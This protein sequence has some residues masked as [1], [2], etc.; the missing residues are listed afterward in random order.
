MKKIINILENAIY[1]IELKMK[2]LSATLN[3]FL[4]DKTIV[5]IILSDPDNFNVNNLKY[6]IPK[7]YL[8]KLEYIEKLQGWYRKFPNEPQVKLALDYLADIELILKEK[9]NRYVRINIKMY[10]QCEQLKKNY[11]MLLK[12]M[13]TYDRNTFI[14]ESELSII[15]D[16]IDDETIDENIIALF[17]YIGKNNAIIRIKQEKGN[18]LFNEL[19]ESIDNKLFDEMNF[20]G[21]QSSSD[22]RI[23]F[24]KIRNIIDNDTMLF[25]IVGNMQVVEEIKKYFTMIFEIECRIT[26]E[27]VEEADIFKEELESIDDS[28]VFMIAI[29][30]LIVDAIEKNNGDMVSTILEGYK[31]SK[32]SKQIN[33]LEKQLLETKKNRLK[34]IIDEYYIEEDYIKFNSAYEDISESQLVKFVGL[35]TIQSMK[36]MELIYIN[37]NRIDTMTLEQ[38]DELITNLEFQMTI[39]KQIQREFDKQTEKFIAD[40]LNI[41]GVSNYVVFL[42]N[43]RIKQ[44]IE[45]ITRE[46]DVNLSLFASAIYKLLMLQPNDLYSRDTCKPIISNGKPN[47]YEIRE[48]RAGTIRI[49]FKAIA[50]FNGK[51]VYEVLG[52]AF[53]ACGDKRKNDNLKESIKEYMSYYPDYQ[54]LENIFRQNDVEQ[55]ECI[56]NDSLDFYN[57]LI[58]KEKNKVKE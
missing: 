31:N 35:E 32:Y 10:Q 6:Q 39:Y 19:E 53:G 25:A 15:E 11:E 58:S 26:D 29:A 51:I 30:L 1:L 55:I 13:K 37:Y 16:L 12:K 8:Y 46:Q 18:D 20:V 36:I 17:L 52:F 2:A 21:E 42:N 24:T 22:A 48:E 7:E 4:M 41:D 23:L 44:N 57:S 43:E 3:T 27:I 54:R 33:S 38:L 49:C 14:E 47:E 5:D 50:S 56:I 45:K 9:R 40:G 34:Q 28:D